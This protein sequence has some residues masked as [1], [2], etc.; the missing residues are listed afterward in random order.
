[1]DTQIINK[2]CGLVAFLSDSATEH[3]AITSMSKSNFWVDDIAQA[4][5]YSTQ[6][7]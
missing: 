5:F 7:S 6:A 3:F 2:V 1:M 4:N